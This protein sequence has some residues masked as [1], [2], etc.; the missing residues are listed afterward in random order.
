MKRQFRDWDKLY[1]QY[2][3]TNL[4]VAAFA[5]KRKKQNCIGNGQYSS[6]I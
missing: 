2:K 3:Q 4:S 5:E 1:A 6:A